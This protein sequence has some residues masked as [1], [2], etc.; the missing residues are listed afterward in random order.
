MN[1][2]IEAA[3]RM[4]A[5]KYGA[6][7]LSELVTWADAIIL[8]LENPPTELFDVSLAKSVSQTVSALNQLGV[9]AL[10]NK[11]ELSK[12]V[13][14]IFHNYL[15]SE[16]PN[17]E[18]ISKALFDMY[19]ENLI[20]DAESG[21]YMVSYWDELDLAELGHYGNVEEV[22]LSMKNLINEKKR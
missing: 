22:K 14:G 9:G 21:T 19:M 13:F 6:I 12:S 18:R 8:E 5:V 11:S 20:P 3:A 7:E 4:I 16:N 10:C 2:E 15:N 1:I 17:Y